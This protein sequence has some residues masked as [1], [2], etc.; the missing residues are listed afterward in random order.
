LAMA[1]RQAPDELP[2]KMYIPLEV[3]QD[4]KECYRQ[5]LVGLIL[6]SAELSGAFPRSM[7]FHSPEDCSSF[8]SL[9]CFLY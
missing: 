7:F 1:S 8:V 2:V 3:M 5:R 4:L 6:R 9:Y